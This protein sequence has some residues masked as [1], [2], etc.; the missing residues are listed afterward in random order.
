MRKPQLLLTWCFLFI[1]GLL[2]FCS[3]ATSASSFENRLHEGHLCPRNSLWFSA[4][5]FTLKLEAKE[6]QESPSWVLQLLENDDTLLKVKGIVSPKDNAEAEVILIAGR[7]LITKNIEMQENHVIDVLDGAALLQQLAL[8]L[9]DLA[10]EKGPRD[11]SFPFHAN[12]AEERYPIK[13]TTPSA[14]GSYTAPWEATIDLIKNDKDIIDYRISF[15]FT[16]L[17]GKKADMKL[18]GQLSNYAEK[19]ANKGLTNDFNI[20]GWKQYNIGPYTKKTSAGTIY[21]FG[22]TYIEPPFST[23]G[24]LRKYIEEKKGMNK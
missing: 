23:L 13:V 14:G 9:I 4:R 20:D 18:T 1:F 6:T 17:Q 24:Q 7:V 10:S 2:L 16:S 8:T 21:D 19:N 11:T 3:K 12:I 5:D 22:T 15:S